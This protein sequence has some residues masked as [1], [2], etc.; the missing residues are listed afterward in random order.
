MK[1]YAV[2]SHC[3]ELGVAKKGDYQEQPTISY[4]NSP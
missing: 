1:A 2:A 4:R 3:A